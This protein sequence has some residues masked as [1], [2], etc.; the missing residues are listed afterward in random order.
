M[1]LSRRRAEASNAMANAYRSA[2]GLAARANEV[3]FRTERGDKDNDSQMKRIWFIV[4]GYRMLI[5]TPCCR[6][7]AGRQA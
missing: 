2:W 5:E 3:I 6:S 1:M 7:T 4:G